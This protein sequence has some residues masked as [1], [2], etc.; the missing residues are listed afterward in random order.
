MGRP[1]RASGE[2]TKERILT[3]AIPL[4][5]AAGFAGTS[6][7]MVADAADVNVATLA[8]HFSDKQGLYDAVV[9]RLHEDI[10]VD[11]AQ[12]TDLST[13]GSTP[14]DVLDAVIVVAWR[15]MNAHRDNIRLLLRHVLDQGK[16]PGVVMDNWAPGLMAQADGLVAAFRPDWP[17]AHRRMLVTTLQHVMARLA[18]EDREQLAQMLGGTDDL[19]AVVVSYFQAMARRELGLLTD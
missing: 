13:A 3:R 10:G 19:D 1:S 5:A 2:K 18:I 16:H 14:A 9:Q 7:R 17:V 6:V 11:F 4:F 12:Y 8:Y 15:F